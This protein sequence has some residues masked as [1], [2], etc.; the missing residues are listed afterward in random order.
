MVYQLTYIAI[1]GYESIKSIPI[2]AKNV[3][4]GH[5]KRAAMTARFHL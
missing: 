5:K 4:S 1:A 2:D 3:Y